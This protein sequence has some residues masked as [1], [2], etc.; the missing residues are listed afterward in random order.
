[1]SHPLLQKLRPYFERAKDN[2]IYMVAKYW[3][4][5]PPGQILE[6]GPRDEPLLEG[7]ASLGFDVSGIDLLP[8][9]PVQVLD[10]LGKPFKLKRTVQWTQGDF[11]AAPLLSSTIDTVISASAIEHFGLGT[12]REPTSTF[13]REFYDVIAMHRIWS[14]LK[15]GGRAYITVPYGGRFFTRGNNWRVYDHEALSNRIVQNFMVEQMAFF[16]GHPPERFTQ[17]IS[18]EEANQHINDPDA[19]VFLK[20]IKR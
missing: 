7:L 2:D 3:S 14:L 5:T 9:E 16:L 11:C 1:M 10:W 12:Y 6:V 15:P 8:F 20:L 17:E 19:A 18:I 13:R 4:E